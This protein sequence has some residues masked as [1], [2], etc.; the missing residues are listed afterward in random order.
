M[1]W[2][3]KFAYKVVHTILLWYFKISFVLMV[4]PPKSSMHLCFLKKKKKIASL[5]FYSLVPTISLFSS[6][7]NSVFIFS[8]SSLLL[9]LSLPFSPSFLSWK[10]YSFFMSF[11]FLYIGI[12]IWLQH[13][14]SAVISIFISHFHSPAFNRPVSHLGDIPNACFPA[15][16]SSQNHHCQCHLEARKWS[17]GEEGSYRKQ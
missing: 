9:S 15:I 2:I 17:L 8:N 1:L 10:F 13:I 3:L 5:S 11:V 16:P 4:I 12:L 7:I 14:D 6:P